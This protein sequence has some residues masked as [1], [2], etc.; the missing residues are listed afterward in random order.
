[1]RRCPFR[2]GAEGR[3]DLNVSMAAT[4][5]DDIAAGLG[6][7]GSMRRRSLMVATRSARTLQGTAADRRRF[8]A[9]ADSQPAEIDTPSGIAAP[10]VIVASFALLGSFPGLGKD[11]PHRLPA[12]VAG[13]R[14]WRRG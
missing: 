1:M 4:D 3:H 5:Q 12:L 13:L 9:V 14:R 11:V 8:S 7:H 6:H 10:G 2:P